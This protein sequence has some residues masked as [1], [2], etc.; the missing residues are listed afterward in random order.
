ML[1]KV[2]PIGEKVTEVNVP[3]GSTVAEIL[4]IA[5]V[6]ANERTITVNNMTA[7]L[8]TPVTADNTVLALAG[9]QKGGVR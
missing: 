3:N 5:D 1:V 9:K 2:A 6:Y 7:S 8:S 4:E